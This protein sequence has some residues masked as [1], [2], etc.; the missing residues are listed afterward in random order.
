MTKLM[1]NLYNKDNNELIEWIPNLKRLLKLKWINTNSEFIKEEVK[2]LSPLTK[3][4]PKEN[5]YFIKYSEL[6]LST[7][8]ENSLRA[9]YEIYKASNKTPHG[10]I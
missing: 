10:M 1:I 8:E 7:E 3:L 9:K 6:N 5:D 2:I 4:V